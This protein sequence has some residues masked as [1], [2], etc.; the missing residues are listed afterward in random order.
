MNYS[1]IYYDIIE[2]RK[3][4]KY[5]GY[6]EN[7]HVLPESLG[8]SDEDYN[9]VRLTAK[10]HYICHL[11]LTKM[12]DEGSVEYYKMIHAF[13][14]MKNAIHNGRHITSR[15]YENL[16]QINAEYMSKTRKGVSTGLKWICNDSTGESKMVSIDDLITVGWRRGSL[17]GKGIERTN[18]TKQ[19][20]KNTKKL[21]NKPNLNVGIKWFHNIE[22]ETCKKFNINNVPEGWVIGRVLDWEE[23]KSNRCDRCEKQL[24]VK[25]NKHK[26]IKFCSDKCRYNKDHKKGYIWIYNIVTKETMHWNSNIALPENF[27]IGRKLIHEKE[28]SEF[29]SKPGYKWIHEISSGINKQVSIEIAIEKG[30]KRGIVRDINQHMLKMLYKNIANQYEDIRKNKQIILD[31]QRYFDLYKIY[32][33][34]GWDEMRSTTGFDASLSNFL[35]K[36]SKLADNY[37]PQPGKKRTAK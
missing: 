17:H 21:N 30:W 37:N 25:M 8:G 20:I 24:L 6:T 4:N 15:K 14:C 7:H 9:R 1:K 18:V 26:Q 31:K 28:Y 3:L 2:H 19:K 5:D 23:F 36:C 11:L 10:E 29:S 13:L 33:E 35:L 22:T 16:K 12:F 27:V 34:V 32:S